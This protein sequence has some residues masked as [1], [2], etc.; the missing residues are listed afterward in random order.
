M[1]LANFT[2]TVR[3]NLDDHDIVFP[4]VYE[5]VLKVLLVLVLI[6]HVCTSTS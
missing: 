3:T 2:S 6:I 5:T 1:E 4:E